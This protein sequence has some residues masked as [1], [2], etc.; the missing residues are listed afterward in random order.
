MRRLGNGAVIA[1]LLVW[2]RRD[3]CPCRSLFRISPPTE[4]TADSGTTY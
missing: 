4:E 1:R 3:W 2:S